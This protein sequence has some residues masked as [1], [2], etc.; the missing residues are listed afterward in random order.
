VEFPWEVF[1]DAGRTLCINLHSTYTKVRYGF[2][3]L[4]LTY[5][6]LG[7]HI[8]VSGRTEMCA[9][10]VRLVLYEVSKERREEVF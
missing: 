7:T 10:I 3:Q 2:G 4:T 6:F 8:S 1:P 5:M 9:S